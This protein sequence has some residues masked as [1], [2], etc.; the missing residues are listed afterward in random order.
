MTADA[1]SLPDG[2]HNLQP[3]LIF[4]NCK[5]A[6]AFYS[7]VFGATER[8]HMDDGKGRTSHAE[9]QLGDSVLMVADE[10][11]EIGA[12]APS[13]FG[14]SPIALMLY[15]E[16]CDTTYHTALE[17]GATSLRE[18]ANQPYG[19]RMSGILDPFGYK[20]WIAHPLPKA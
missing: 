17:A 4:V 5:E 20:W 18:P 13:H 10:H 6:I 12:F 2:Y 19:D 16:H 1:K 8:L 14:G 3:Y 9:L 11:P 7:K 15:V